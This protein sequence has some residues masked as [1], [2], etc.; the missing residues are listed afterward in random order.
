[1]TATELFQIVKDRELTIKVND[2]GQAVVSGNPERLTP[3]L[4]EALKTHRRE[5]IT[6]LGLGTTPIKPVQHETKPDTECLWPGNG[7]IEPHYFPNLGY[8]TGAYFFR[9][10]GETEWKPIPGRTWD[11]ETKRGKVEK[12]K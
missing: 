1:M 5:I 6:L 12:H 2:N 4:V 3:A 9:K 11:E 8:P 10:I 7:Y